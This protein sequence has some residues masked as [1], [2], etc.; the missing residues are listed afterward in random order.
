MAFDLKVGFSC[1]NRC[2]HCVITDKVYCGD[3]NTVQIY[4]IISRLDDKEDLVITGGEPT[5]RKDFFKILEHYKKYKRGKIILQTNGRMF[6]KEQFALESVNLPIDII[7]V[8]VH[9]HSPL[10]HD[11]I[12]GVQGSHKQTIEGIKNLMRLKGEETHIVS[13]TVISKLNIK[14]L[15]KTYDLMFDLGIR[16]MNLTFPHPMGD[17]YKNFNA[18][19]PKYENIKDELQKI[20]KSYGQYINTE[21]IPLCYIYPYQNEVNYSEGIKI[22]NLQEMRGYDAGAG[23]SIED[24]NTMLSEEYRKTP[25]CKTCVFDKNCLGVWKEY[26]EKYQHEMDLYPIRRN[27]EI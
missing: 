20:L 21:A 12:T 2:I 17:A 15:V 8:A 18:V 3:L 1:N 24:Y 5:I 13:Q 9:S 19:V 7:L 25:D 4:D 23:G 6:Y 27:N 16:D 14:N 22:K 11:M 26:Y 10:I